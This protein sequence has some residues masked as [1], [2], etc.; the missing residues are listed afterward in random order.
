[1]KNETRFSFGLNWLDFV[2]TSLDK[3]KVEKA[4]LSMRTILKSEDLS[5]KTFLD[6]G[7]GSGLFSLAACLL[8]AQH[9]Y[10]FD[11][12]ANSVLASIKLRDQFNISELRWEIYQG[13]ILNKKWL[14]IVPQTD[15]VYSW[16]VLHHTGYMWEAIENTILKVKPG[17]LLAIS[18]YNKVSNHRDSSKMW[19]RIKYFYNRSPK[20]LRIIIVDLYILKVILGF[21]RRGINPI[22]EIKAY[23]ER[24]MDFFHDVKDWVGGFPYEYASAEEV[25]QFIKKVHNSD[26]IFINKENGNACNEFTFQF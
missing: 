20:L 11:F 26:L 14:S 1:M 4:L 7:C 19:W 22:R 23:G 6:V 13:D 15:I 8:N 16:G 5:G 25:I 18:I 12:D 2:D 24:G 10:S 9:V 3:T 21:I 17:G